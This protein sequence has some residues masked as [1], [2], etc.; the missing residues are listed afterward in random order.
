MHATLG[1]KAMETAMADATLMIVAID[2]RLT[3]YLVIKWDY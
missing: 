2:T 3:A 1:V